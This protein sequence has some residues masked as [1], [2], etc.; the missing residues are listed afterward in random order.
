MTFCKWCGNQEVEKIDRSKP[1]YDSSTGKKLMRT[2][3]ECPK[4]D[5]FWCNLFAP[6][7]GDM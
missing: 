1:Q 2:K 3:K 4:C 6:G 5:G 7:P